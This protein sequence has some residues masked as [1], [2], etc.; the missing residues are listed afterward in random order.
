VAEFPCNNK[1]HAS[2]PLNRTQKGPN[3]ACK[4][5]KSPRKHLLIHVIIN[6]YNTFNYAKYQKNEN[7]QYIGQITH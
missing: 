5:A 7:K 1:H 4:Q 3:L 2:S 6:I